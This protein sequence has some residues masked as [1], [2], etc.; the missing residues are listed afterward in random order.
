MAKQ[1]YLALN[2]IT[3]LIGLWAL[4]LPAGSAAQTIVNTAHA[5]WNGSGTTFTA[6]SNTFTFSVLQ[7]PVT[8]DTF[9]SAPK[10]GQSL[11]LAPSACGAQASSTGGTA[12][13]TTMTVSAVAATSLH[14]GE[15]FY[16]RVA[17]HDGN[18]DPNAIDV[19]TTKLTTT[20]GDEETI[21][22][23]ETGP[24]TGVFIGALP[25][26]ALPSP[27][28]RGDCRLSVGAQQTIEISVL[29]S[30]AQPVATAKVDVL[31][32]PFGLVFDSEDGSPVDGA[33][34]S[35]VDA[36]S[37]EPAAVFAP[38]GVTAWPSI[39]TAGTTVRDGAGRSY[40]VPPGAFR[41]PLVAPGTYRLVVTPPAPFT[42]PSQATAAQLTGLR[43]ADGNPL[44]I[45]AG[46]FGDPFTIGGFEALRIDLPV[47]RPPV[48]M[49]LT[50]AASKD[51]VEPGDVLFYTLTV[52]NPEASRAKS[53]VVVTDRP[54][55]RL[56]LRPN[57]IRIDRAVP[58]PGEVTIAADGRTLT[59]ALGTVGPAAR[60]VITYAMSVL[61]GASPG[62]AT[63]KAEV[64]D[65][66]G[67][68]A[69]S[70][71]VVTIDPDTLASRMTLVGRIAAGGCAYHGPHL[72]IPRVRVMLEDG[73]FAVTD[74]DGRYHFEGIVPGDHVVAV[75]PETLPQGGL[76]VNC[77]R[78]SR[79][80]M[81]ATSRFVDG[82]GGTLAVA[83]FAAELPA[84][85]TEELVA[86]TA[87]RHRSEENVATPAKAE[88][89]K[90]GEAPSAEALDEEERLQRDAAGADKDWLSLGDGPPAFLFPD[91][92]H[93]PRAPAVRV[94]IRHRPDQ[95]V[96]LTSDGHAVVAAA[97][98]GMRTSADG[99]WAV[100]IWRGIPIENDVIHLAAT[101][102]NPDGKVAVRLTRDLHFTGIAA[103][104]REV[105]EKSI[106]VADGRTRP[107]VAV[108][109]LDRA[110]R[111][112][113]AG[114]SGEFQLSAPYESAEAVDAMQS[115]ALTGL[116]TVGPRWTVKGDDGIALIELAPTLVSGP[117]QLDFT[118]VDG[119]QKRQQTLSAWIL[120]GNQ[121]WTLVGL[122]EGSLGA[123][124]I[125]DSM[126]RTG[127]IDSD[128]GQH[129]RIA[130]YAKGKVPG[131]ALLTIAY[132]SAKQR[133]DQ[134]LLGAIDPRAYYT[135]F[136]DGSSRRFDAAS[137][138]KLYVRIESR[139]F[140][141]MFGDFETGFNDTQLARYQR[142]ATGT[143]AEAHLGGFHAQGFATRL[144]SV[145]HH[146]EI[147][148]GG[149]SGPYPL[150]SKAIIANSET[151]TIETRDR[152]RS[153]V[154]IDSKTLTRFIDYDIDLLSGTITFKS[155][156][157]SRDFNQNPIF[158]VVDYEID[159]NASG[160]KLNA[161]ARVDFTSPG[162]A[163]RIGA[164]AISDTGNGPRTQLG[165]LDLKARIASRTEVRAELAASHGL[166]ETKTAWL[167]EI[168][169]HDGRFD[170]VGYARSMDQSF[171]VGQSTGAE[172]G[173]RKYGIDARY[174]FNEKFSIIG[175]GWTDDSLTDSTH[176]DAIELHGQYRDG[177]NSYTAGV[178]MLRDT[179]ADGSSSPSTT[180]DGGVNRQML[181]G[182]LEVEGA[183]SIGIGETQSVDLPSREELTLRYALNSRVKLVGS[184][185]IAKGANVDTRMARIGFEVTPWTGGRIATSVSQ[186]SIVELGSRSFAA[187]G[188]AQSFDLTKHL[189]INATLD[190]NR[191]IGGINSANVINALHPPAS[192]GQLAQGT[193]AEDFTAVTLGGNWR[194]HLWTAS[195]RGEW[196]DGE[197]ADRRGLTMGVIRQMGDGSVFGSGLTDTQANGI[198]GTASKVIDG[199]VVFA[200]RPA[201]SML[202][203]LAK[204]ELRSDQIANSAIGSLD[205][206]GQTAL[207]VQG[208]ARSTRIVGSISADLS[209]KEQEGDAYVQRQGAGV[210]L[211]ARYTLDNYQDQKL[212]GSAV[213]AGVDAHIGIGE[214]IEIGGTASVRRLM[215]QGVMDFAVGPSVGFV[216]ARDTI[217]TVGYNI[218]GFRDRD[219]SVSR[220]TNRGI[221]ATFKAKFDPSTI[222][223]LG[224]GQ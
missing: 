19:L 107:V 17:D 23:Y 142:I 191:A 151:V 215:G 58:Q 86:L 49:G 161:G 90:P 50:K 170:I 183:A 37:G 165:G 13:R 74:D 176:R 145:H 111:P 83:D 62:Q 222:A 98:D 185:E 99:H 124:T 18:R 217:L 51:R 141:A 115:R 221:F 186:Q 89:L 80:A 213:L 22:I 204:L 81:S 113:H 112:V 148:G 11:T 133:D 26:S 54:D 28:V 78:S 138:N 96:E 92:G 47:D 103:Q 207:S 102:R 169:H 131:S 109:I 3:L 73:S 52:T 219:F 55:V 63:N 43:R 101:I 100:S 59:V 24:D 184:Y 61:P 129:A 177:Q 7:K 38:D 93:N 14:I 1:P 175:S 110:G 16:V 178:S 163:V 9:V 68:A 35:L 29:S 190:S 20:G 192:G 105:T 120:P 46:S 150:S 166:G 154:I 210:F 132:D 119:Q 128:L 67:P 139:A 41:F 172:Q 21:Q 206:A 69:Y 155:P 144:A 32:D 158:I 174:L 48:A 76:F 149:I 44:E 203:V 125:A 85:A 127:R 10:G 66:R 147:Q 27:P 188:L 212:S 53:E 33:T 140:Y 79:N 36:N 200:H 168:E 2:L 218:V 75:S 122:A 146:D 57:T 56:R 71:A 8:I 171:G 87:K 182:R 211:A 209:P 153:E 64:T 94:V 84:A 88:P 77:A 72:G 114:L 25:A 123:R 39:V 208:D 137:R 91:A 135:V 202:A 70:S 164:T 198:D 116:G 214:R 156:V 42:A 173:R 167:A 187:F 108:R 162:G 180:L 130:F 60:H 117:L 199:A 201:D 30:S 95:K 34:V 40:D 223:F 189:T 157:L 216:P 4:L 45:T 5:T 15:T 194:S 31:A 136:A 143:K 160:G 121:K 159:Q 118:F 126:Q 224:L 220:S 82:T 196:R 193:V 97:F 134:Q 12:A 106:L 195:I 181:D 65:R 197:F 6:D 152:F 179:L 205:D 104:V